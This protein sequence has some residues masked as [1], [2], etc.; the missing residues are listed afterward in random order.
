MIHPSRS[1]IRGSQAIDTDVTSLASFD[2]YSRMEQACS[3]HTEV[4]FCSSSNAVCQCILEKVVAITPSERWM[5]TVAI[6]SHEVV[7]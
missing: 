6:E 7:D 1:L 4:D 5:R 3:S 2:C